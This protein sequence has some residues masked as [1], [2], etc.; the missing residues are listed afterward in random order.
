[1]ICGQL[2]FYT[3]SLHF[4]I[5]VLGAEKCL[6]EHCGLRFFGLRPKPVLAIHNPSGGIKV[7][8]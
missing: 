4:A 3:V 8:L 5:L 1:M 6:V 7:R 2:P